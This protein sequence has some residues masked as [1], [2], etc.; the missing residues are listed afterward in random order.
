MNEN[1]QS[2]ILQQQKA[3][4][5]AIESMDKGEAIEEEW[6]PSLDVIDSIREDIER[7]RARRPPIVT[8]SQAPPGRKFIL[9]VLKQSLPIVTPSLPVGLNTPEYERKE[10]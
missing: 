2:K 6:Q 7:E 9:A 3:L 1:K 8:V 4:L 10:E 5:D